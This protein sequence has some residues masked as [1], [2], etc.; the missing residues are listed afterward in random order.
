MIYRSAHDATNISKVM[1]WNDGSVNRVVKW[2]SAGEDW[3]RVHLV[4]R[5][6]RTEQRTYINT[7]RE[8]YET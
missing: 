1:T 5:I 6:L 8:D 2:W 7:Q 3:I 4:T